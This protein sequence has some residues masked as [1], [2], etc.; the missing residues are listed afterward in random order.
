MSINTLFYYRL[1]QQLREQLV[2]SGW[3]DDM[4]RHCKGGSHSVTVARCAEVLWLIPLACMIILVD[5][6]K[7]K[8]LEKITVDDLVAEITPHGRG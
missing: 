4:R 5:V 8:G 6:I 7:S 1:K 3:F 2:A